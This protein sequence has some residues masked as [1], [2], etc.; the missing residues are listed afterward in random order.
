MYVGRGCRDVTFSSPDGANPAKFYVNSAPAHRE[1]P[2]KQIS[3][4]DAEVV[5]L[6]T[7]ET[8][9]HRT[10]TKLL[11]NSKAETC[12]LQMGMTE[13]KPGSVWNTVPEHTHDRRM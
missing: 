7:N 6:G 13:L 4:Q 5:T 8:S 11:V 3:K 1:F 9:N 10:I 2:L 12:Q